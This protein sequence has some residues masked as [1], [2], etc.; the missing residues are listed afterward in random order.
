MTLADDVIELNLK[1]PNFGG[2]S[3]FRRTLALDIFAGRVPWTEI[4]LGSTIVEGRLFQC[5][6]FDT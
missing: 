6:G 3:N 5:Q 1:G 4:I 2:S